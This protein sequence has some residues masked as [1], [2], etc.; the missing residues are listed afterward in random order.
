MARSETFLRKAGKSIQKWVGSNNQQCAVKCCEPSQ[1]PN[2][3][4]SLS[5]AVASRLA[6]LG[7]CPKTFPT[8]T[9]LHRL[10]GPT[11]QAMVSSRGRNGRL[12]S[13][14]T[15]RLE[16]RRYGV[17]PTFLSAGGET[18]QSRRTKLAAG[19]RREEFAVSAL[20][21]LRACLDAAR[22]RDSFAARWRETSPAS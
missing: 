15:C 14:P 17:A 7:Q 2:G 3:I 21:R 18:F 6:T 9:G 20:H 13:L 1:N 11:H 4:P 5:P 22:P 10:P 12:E 19:S 8:P 16:S